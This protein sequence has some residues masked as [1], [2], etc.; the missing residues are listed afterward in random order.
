MAQFN[1]LQVFQSMQGSANARLEQSASLTEGM[2]AAIWN[3]HHDH[4]D[5]LSPTH[6]TLSCYL[7]GGRDT[8]RR[9][10]PQQTGAPNKLCVL[11]AGHQSSWVI[12]NSLRLIHLYVSPAQLA[13]TGVQLLDRD[14]REF[15]LH[16]GIFIDDPQ[17]AQRFRLLSQLDW[18]EP[19][20][21]LLL[22]SLSHELLC[23]SL[24]QHNRRKACL[25]LRGGLAAHQRRRVQEYI[26]AHLDSPLSL[27]DLAQLCALSP[28]HFA[29][30]FQRSCGLPPHRYVLA[31]RLA[32]ARQLLAQPHLSIA[33]VALD[34]GFASSSHLHQRFRQAFAAT[35]GQY[36]NAMG[37]GQRS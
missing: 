5:Y 33:Q 23:H 19:S 3:N 12:G 14:L 27:D 11:P 34:C 1:E 9:D 4:R 2:A 21:R 7:E 16:E 29:R 31:R 15:D 25:Q 32:K 8:F 26:D 37:L 18:Q 10:Q 35:P 28:Y 24:L 36:R 30:M 17:Q 22:T 6:H 20:Q 13:L